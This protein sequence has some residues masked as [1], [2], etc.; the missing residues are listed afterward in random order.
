M[1]K[2]KTK[3][4][5]RILTTSFN[6]TST[7]WYHLFAWSWITWILIHRC[8]F[9]TFLLLIFLFILWSHGR[10]LVCPWHL[11]ATRGR[12]CRNRRQHRLR[13]TWIHF[14]ERGKEFF[15]TVNSG[16]LPM[17]CYVEPPLL[18]LLTSY[19]LLSRGYWWL[20]WLFFLLSWIEFHKHCK[21]TALH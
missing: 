9:I 18:L 2:R 5:W 3:T 17:D 8:L 1:E 6:K 19:W 12:E 7:S 10:G 4:K 13:W 11:D 16:E 14:R 20:R 21:E 15:G